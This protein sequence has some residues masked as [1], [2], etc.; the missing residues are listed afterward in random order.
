MSQSETSV[1]PWPPVDPRPD[2]LERVADERAV[3]E[4]LD[5]L[6]DGDCRAILAATSDDA[7][8]TSELSD[9]CELPLSTTYRKV[10]LL[11]DVGALAECTR[12]RPSGK[13]TSEYRRRL[14]SVFVSLDG[15]GSMELLVS[16][17]DRHS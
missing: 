13:H 2:R 7:L 11:E 15:N 17:H 5:V 14:H 10:E 1:G 3:Q 16:M 9:A 12:L 4:L 6:D 8:S